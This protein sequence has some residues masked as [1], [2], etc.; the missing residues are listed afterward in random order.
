MNVLVSLFAILVSA[1]T[2]TQGV[3]ALSAG[4]RLRERISKDLAIL[5]ELPPGSLRDELS[6]SIQEATIQMVVT[7]K[8][9]P[10]WYVLPFI[11]ISTTVSAVVI[12]WVWTES[13]PPVDMI[14]PVLGTYLGA[15]FV[16][17]GERE[18]LKNQREPLAKRLRAEARAAGGHA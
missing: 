9:R 5:K 13:G 10:R 18:S 11:T 6:A 15:G 14:F 4:T 8:Y 17:F 2:I 12:I 16:L 1:L 7:E 3:R